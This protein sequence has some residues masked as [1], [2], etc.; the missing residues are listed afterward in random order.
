MTNA[1]WAL[2]ITQQSTFLLVTSGDYLTRLARFA[3]AVS[4]QLTGKRNFAPMHAFCV[5]AMAD[6]LDRVDKQKVVQFIASPP[7]SQRFLCG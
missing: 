4:A 2:D 5:L 6:C 7:T 1:F 3:F